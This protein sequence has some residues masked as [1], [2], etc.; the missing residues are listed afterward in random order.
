MERA[1]L[2]LTLRSFAHSLT[3]SITHSLT[4]SRSPQVERAV[5]LPLRRRLFLLGMFG[6]VWAVS[7]RRRSCRWPWHLL[8]C[9]VLPTPRAPHTRWSAYG[10]AA[11]MGCG[12]A[13]MLFPPTRW[14]LMRWV[15]PKPGQGPSP[16][17]RRT[18]HFHAC[19]L[20][21][22]PS[23]RDATLSRMPSSA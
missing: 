11:A 2:T 14:A 1:T 20:Y 13:L 19:L 4:Y 6:G 21:T 22:S 9:P 23:P 17:L 5:R 18:G 7:S 16:E 12:G 3:H 15:L 8:T 10:S